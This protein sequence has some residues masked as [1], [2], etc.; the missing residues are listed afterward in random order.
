ML[1]SCCIDVGKWMAR[2]FL[3]VDPTIA[4][5]VRVPHHAVYIFLCRWPERFGTQAGE[6]ML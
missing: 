4:I 5:G 3:I 2:T 1:A 6:N